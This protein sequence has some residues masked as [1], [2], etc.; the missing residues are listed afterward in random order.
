MSEFILC[1]RYGEIEAVQEIL[2]QTQSKQELVS[3]DNNKAVFMAAGNGHTDVLKLLLCHITLDTINT[4]NEEGSRPLHWAA[5][6]GQLESCRLLLAAGAS[7]TLRNNSGYS[8]ATLAEQ[9]EHLEVAS[10]LLTSYDPEIEE[11]GDEETP[12]DKDIIVSSEDPGYKKFAE[13]VK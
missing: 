8:A 10:L 12:A 13:M 1:C 11:E 5:L 6:N 4:G 9:K 3:R 7:A 2:S